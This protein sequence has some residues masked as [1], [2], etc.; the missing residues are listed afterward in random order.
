MTLP[1]VRHCKYRLLFIIFKISD[2][3]VNTIS[4]ENKRFFY[5]LIK[6]ISLR[7]EV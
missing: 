5:I 4:G 2:P 3:S 1:E 6:I 7:W